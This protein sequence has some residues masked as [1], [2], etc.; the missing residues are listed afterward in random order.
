MLRIALPTDGGRLCPHFGRSPAFTIV[1]ADPDAK[2]IT[3]STLVE[4]EAGGECSD[5]I[6]MLKRENVEALIA[7]GIGA[8][9]V[10]NLM[11]Q[12]IKVIAGAPDG[13]IEETVMSFMRGE[14][15]C[16]KSTCDHDHDHHH[17][18]DHSCGHHH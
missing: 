11:Q 12:G 16:G 6:T 2:S 13:G 5:A 15:V 4:R 17:D 18:H 9:A 7:S 14:L 8:G 3:S 1:D 10:A